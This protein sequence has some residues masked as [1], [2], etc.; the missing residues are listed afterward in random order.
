[1]S[2]AQNLAVLAHELRAPVSALQ[3]LADAANAGPESARRR[4][5][6]LAI[7]AGRDVERILADP[8]LRFYERE[9]VAVD[10]LVAAVTLLDPARVTA[11]VEPELVVTGDPT[12]L[13]QALVNLAANGLRHG[14]SVTLTATSDDRRVVIEVADDGPG[15]PDGIDIFARG[16][17]E[18]GSTGLG[19][20]LAR[21]IAEAHG[22][23]VELVPT[24][25]GATFRLVLPSSGA[26]L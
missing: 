3:A 16:A 15:V 7:A 17:G 10:A 22:G 25:V 5:F 23:T 4:I 13:R 18:A 20:W 11:Q 9:P 24:G 8:E 26:G 21:T 1:M 19:L 14:V 6:A 2:Q 12:R